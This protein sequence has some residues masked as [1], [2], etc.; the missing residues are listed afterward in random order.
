MHKY[1]E[2]K[3]EMLFVVINRDVG[4]MDVYGKKVETIRNGT[5]EVFSKEALER[6]V[7]CSLHVSMSY[8]DLR[9][10]NMILFAVNFPTKPRGPQDSSQIISALKKFD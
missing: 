9:D 2:F 5:V 7:D 8:Y 3:P 4:V 6:V 10:T 1:H